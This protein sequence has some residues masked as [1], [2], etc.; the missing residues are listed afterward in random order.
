MKKIYKLD[1]KIHKGFILFLTLCLAVIS[2]LPV[3]RNN[4]QAASDKSNLI[5]NTK[6]AISQEGSDVTGEKQLNPEKDITVKLS[7]TFPILKNGNI[8]IYKEED[9]NFNEDKQ[10]DEGDEATIA[11]GK[12]IRYKGTAKNI[13]IYQTKT[14]QI[15]GYMDIVYNDEKATSTAK[16]HFMSKVDDPNG[17]FDYEPEQ[18]TNVTV[19]FQGN[20]EATKKEGANPPGKDD[21]LVILDK[22]YPLPSKEAVEKVDLK[23]NGEQ[24]D[25]DVVEWKIEATRKLDG[26]AASLKDFVI[27]DDISKVGEILPNSFTV[28]GVAVAD[29]EIYDAKNKTIHYK[30]S[31]TDGI[32][33]IIKFKTKIDWQGETSKKLKNKA[34]LTT[35]DDKTVEKEVEVPVGSLPDISKSY[36][37]AKLDMDTNEKSLLWTIK[38]GKGTINYGPAWVGDILSTS[39][40]NLEAPKRIEI[41]VEK[42]GADGKWSLVECGEATTGDDRPKYPSEDEK[43]P[44]I[45]DKYKEKEIY[46]FGE[47][48]QE[49]NKAIPEDPF[50]IL[51]SYWFFLPKL[52]TEYKIEVKQVF[53]KKANILPGTV[54]NNAEVNV[55]NGGVTPIKPP[56]YTGAATIVKKAEKTQDDSLRQG[57][58]PWDITVNLSGVFPADPQFAYEIFY[59]GKES[60]FNAQKDKLVIDEELPEGTFDKLLKEETV[61]FNVAYVDG[62]LESSPSNPNPVKVK[63]ILPIKYNDTQVGEVVQIEGFN[64]PA[65]YN[66]SLKTQMQNL[67]DIV[68]VDGNINL[69]DIPNHVSFVSGKGET[70]K[71]LKAN[72]Y[73]SFKG[74]MFDKIALE[75][76]TDL[77]NMKSVSKDNNS[78]FWSEQDNVN[79]SRV[80]NHKDRTAYFRIDVNPYGLDI[81]QYKKDLKLKTDITKLSDSLSVTDKLPANWKLVPIDESGAMFTMYKAKPGTIYWTDY[82]II[83][84][85][86]NFFSEIQEPSATSRMSTEEINNVVKFNEDK[87]QWDFKKPSGDTY[88]IIIKAQ[89]DENVYR[90]LV[91][92]GKQS[93]DGASYTNN[94]NM[95]VDQNLKLSAGKEVKVIPT[96]LSKEK[97][98]WI[99]GSSPEEPILDWTIF[100]RPMD[101]PGIQNPTLVDELDENLEVPVGKDGNPD[102]SLIHVQRSNEL[103]GDGTYDNYKDVPVGT[104]VGKNQV[105]ILYKPDDHQ[106][107]FTLPKDTEGVEPYSYK[108]VYRTLLQPLNPNVDIIHNKVKLKAKN[109]KPGAEGSVEESL[110]NNKAWADLKKFPF[111]VFKKVSAKDGKQLPGATFEFLRDGNVVVTKTSN[112]SGKIYL[113]NPKD[114]TYTMRETSAPK[115]F[116]PCEDILFKIENGKLTV[117]GD[118]YA[119]INGEG[120]LG[121]PVL[122]VDKEK[123]ENPD[124]PEPKDPDKPTPNNPN[125]PTPNGHKKH[126]KIN[127]AEKN[128]PETGDNLG[129][130]AMGTLL[131]IST[132]A[133]LLIIKK[134]ALNK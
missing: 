60:D 105:G 53:D 114:G 86:A 78:S 102:L 33:G 24:I 19:Y 61:N 14:G 96:I 123:P 13:P 83:V 104:K 121:N 2:I 89:L 110:E 88:M 131:I 76:D 29:K 125:E 108:I 132:G 59:Y 50:K 73:Y 95:V 41:K 34:I 109:V 47:G 90:E 94:S 112:A 39:D 93:D 98:N 17:K 106:L 81:P 40:E 133:L 12:N 80:F 63:Q 36:S 122:I 54:Q 68:S 44:T 56:I 72:A 117:V 91:K 97:P 18:L 46:H 126:K 130:M 38:V 57:K 85:G 82:S 100:Y 49:P 37:G 25:L 111:F 134:K 120:T 52:D 48:F 70:L 11:L 116:L 101:V 64:Q 32:G 92:N 66:F 3:L 8:P 1:N 27:K 7:F 26:K 113:I 10:V 118:I 42:L 103:K 99:L 4:V 28:N 87:L 115:N 74:D 124:K 20:F 58:L 43:C 55:C 129:G 31:N 127:K 119:K 79:D 15:V 65:E 9:H 71:L 62:S 22:S 5:T 128:A 35:P 30:F 69:K 67:L 84:G 16:V 45:P 21:Y 6:V 23:K 107:I 75:Y 51:K 77:N